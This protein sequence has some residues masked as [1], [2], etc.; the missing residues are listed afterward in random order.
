LQ[1]L[2]EGLEDSQELG[3]HDKTKAAADTPGGCFDV[4]SGAT[5][6]QGPKAASKQKQVGSSMHDLQAQQVH[7]VH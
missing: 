3:W 2:V 4:V 1:Q 5:C 7:A 6:V